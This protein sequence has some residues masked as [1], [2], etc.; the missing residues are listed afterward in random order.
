MRATN[1]DN[2]YI[3]CRTN[4]ARCKICKIERLAAFFSEI[5]WVAGDFL[6]SCISCRCQGVFV[7]K[8]RWRGPL[9]RGFP[10]ALRGLTPTQQAAA[11]PKRG[12]KVTV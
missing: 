4:S 2:T 12:T 11:D 5:E 7:E 8:P 3:C 10:R 9:H 1:A 6:Q